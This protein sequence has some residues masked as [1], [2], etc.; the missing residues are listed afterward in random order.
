LTI[1]RQKWREETAYKALVSDFS[2]VVS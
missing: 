2:S 1:S